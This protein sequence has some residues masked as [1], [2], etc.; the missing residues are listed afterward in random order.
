M[1]MTTEWA[2]HFCDE[3]APR[4]RGPTTMMLMPTN[5]SGY[6][7]SSQSI[8]IGKSDLID[9]DSIDQSVEIDDTVSSFIDLSWFLSISP[10]YSG[11]YVRLFICSSKNEN[12]IHTNGK[13]CWQN[14]R[15]AIDRNLEPKDQTTCL[16]LQEC[17]N[18]LGATI[19]RQFS[20]SRSATLS[21]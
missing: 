6:P 5:R 10:I 8:K 14:D 21:K 1:F 9:I 2:R 19:S 7:R 4:P 3:F 17:G 12:W 15:V 16:C 18:G 13:V 11:R 20:R